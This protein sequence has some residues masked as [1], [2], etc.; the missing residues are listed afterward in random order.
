VGDPKEG[1]DTRRVAAT[2]DPG[3]LRVARSHSFGELLLGEVVLHSVLDDEPRDL[4]EADPSLSLGAVGR[5]SL[6]PTL[7]RHRCGPADGT[8]GFDLRNCLVLDHVLNLSHVISH[9]K[10][11]PSYGSTAGEDIGKVTTDLC[12]ALVES[13]QFWR[14]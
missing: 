1:V 6:S 5:A 8:Q 9:A 7:A 11:R 14:G 12:D 13:G 2:L 3:D 4:P 10:G